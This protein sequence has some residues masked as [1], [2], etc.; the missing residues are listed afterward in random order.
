[1]PCPRP[2]SGI[3]AR[4]QVHD[5]VEWIAGRARRADLA[6]QIG[7]HPGVGQLVER[8]HIDRVLH[9]GESIA[10]AAAAALPVVPMPWSAPDSDPDPDP[11]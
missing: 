5:H 1:L 9:G 2:R 4:R 7:Q 6:D 11:A 10:R 8:P 3:V